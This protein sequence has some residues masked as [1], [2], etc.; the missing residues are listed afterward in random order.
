MKAIVS[1]LIVLMVV[2]VSAHAVS[3]D[4]QST[5]GKIVVVMKTNMGTIDIELDTHKA[6]ITV[7]NFLK[8]VMASHYDSTVMHRVIKGFMLQG[9]G[10][11]T[12]FQK[13]ET[14]PPIKNEATN[15]LKNKRGT[16]AMARTGIV[17]SATNQFFI[18]HSDNDFLDH[19]EKSQEGFG[20][21]VFGK[22]VKGM[23]V[24][25]KIANVSVRRGTISEAVP[26]TPVIIESIRIKD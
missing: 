24:V 11:T 4:A 14:N 12:D 26:V 6:P 3:V 1:S 19:K 7:A 16:I 18:N 22:V 10:Y 21:C 8:Y 23:K 13:K 9:G 5:G 15:G 17:D 25:D 20:Y 2:L